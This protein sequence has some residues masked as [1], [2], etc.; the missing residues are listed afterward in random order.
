MTAMP[1]QLSAGFLLNIFSVSNTG[2]W[3]FLAMNVNVALGGYL[4]S[5]AAFRGSE[6]KAV[7]FFA[8]IL[9]SYASIIFICTLAGAAGLLRATP[10]LLM[11]LA[12]LLAAILLHTLSPTPNSGSEFHDSAE[13][14]KEPPDIIAIGFV[15]VA[16]L[17][18]MM[19]FIWGVISPPPPWDAY[20][21]HLP[22]AATWLQD[23]RISLVTV[24]FGDQAGTYFPSNTELY[25]AWLMLPLKSEMLT[26][27][28]QF[29]FYCAAALL[30]WRIGTI[31][32]LNRY[33]AAASGALF[34]L[35]PGI[36]HQSVASEVDIVFCSLFLLS[37]YFMLVYLDGENRAACAALS[38]LAIGL[39]AGT[40]YIGLTF[41]PI[42]A[43]PS[44]WIFLK[45][46]KPRHA[47]AYIL[48]A[49]CGC[50]YWYV[51]NLAATG[52]PVFPLTISFFG[53][54][55][56][57]GG[58]TRE[59]MT[60]AV[61]HAKSAADWLDA[62]KTTTGV[63]LGIALGAG[64]ILGPAIFFIQ[65]RLSS[66]R[67]LLVLLLAP[68][69]IAVF[70][71]LIPYNLESRFTY[72]AL[73][74]ACI[75][76]GYLIGNE[77]IFIKMIATV[78]VFVA[79]ATSIDNDVF[80]GPLA[81]TMLNLIFGADLV[82]AGVARSSAIYSMLRP[83]AIMLF[84][85][86]LSAGIAFLLLIVTS[87]TDRMKRFALPLFAVSL[88]AF[89]ASVFATLPS[90]RSYRLLYN[91]DFQVGLAW[92]YLDRYQSQKGPGA[93]R[94]SFTG[95]DLC[96]GLYGGSLQNKVYSAA[97][98]AHPDWKFHDC[99]A[100]VKRLGQYRVP[101]TDRIDF[102]RRNPDA[103]AWISNLARERTDF[104]FISTLHQN[105]LPHLPHDAEGFPIEYGWA[106]S[107][108]D[109]F[110]PIYTNT[111]V[112]IYRLSPVAGE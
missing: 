61:F 18:S 41:A 53:M 89:L 110:H 60:Y 54:T 35:V 73:A 13:I 20:V 38:G 25:Y 9:I 66:R 45:C 105:D 22:F 83:G 14:E 48:L 56:F 12:V 70:A 10:L 101:H 71:F 64:M 99:V 36:M 51:R 23:G 32:G 5:G 3:L 44:L 28:G 81:K 15:C 100:E 33:A 43:I 93:A 34:A 50:A 78:G 21:Y 19:L 58:Y 6:H 102:C 79:A 47:A 88:I 30:A 86:A 74:I 103:S 109:I 97:I 62:M 11:S 55:I 37:L 31:L 52:N 85:C 69:M 91:P 65:K 68:L 75:S 17:I 1:E 92:N 40:K 112:M 49:A 111:Q 82:G 95:T 24:P 59:S 27:A 57:P 76:L 8:W 106:K 4:L 16:V 2:L 29:P 7:R 72:P 90:Y 96:F 39:L 63:P 87:A 98:T 46:K 84:I 108:P 80:A 107:R 67:A 94:I 104:V 26:N 42:L 77:N